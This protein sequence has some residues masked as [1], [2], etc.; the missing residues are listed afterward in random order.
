MNGQRW[1]V[2]FAPMPRSENHSINLNVQSERACM[3]A[4][5]ID[6]LQESIFR[7]KQVS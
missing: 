1:L 7:L 3:N 2:A 5:R 4:I 6:M